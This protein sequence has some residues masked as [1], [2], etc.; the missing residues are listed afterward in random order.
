MF[1]IQENLG[2]D[3]Q[4]LRTL[5]FAL[6]APL[7][8]EMEESASHHLFALR[9]CAPKCLKMMP[10]GSRKHSESGKSKIMGTLKIKIFH[11]AR[12]LLT[13]TL[14]FNRLPEHV[15][16]RTEMTKSG[17][18]TLQEELHLNFRKTFPATCENSEPGILPSGPHWEEKWRRVLRTTYLLCAAARRSA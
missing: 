13:S 18:E 11:L 15:S 7:G 3:M 10:A 1:E 4:K 8:G 14:R 16:Q 9:C 5:N 17:V 6:W 2:N 12:T